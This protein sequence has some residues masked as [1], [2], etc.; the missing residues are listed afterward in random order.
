MDVHAFLDRVFQHLP[1]PPIRHYEFRSWNISEYPTN[2]G[3]GMLPVQGLDPD[4]FIKHVMDVDHYVGN[5]GFVVDN[6]SES[7]DASGAKVRFYQRLKLPVIGAIQHKLE[8]V[9]GGERDG[10]RFAYW[11]MLEDE[12][13]AL[14]PKKGARS[15]Y[16]NGAWLIGHDAVGYALSSGPRR[17]DVGRLTWLALTKGANATAKPTVKQN[18]EGMVR[19]V[20]GK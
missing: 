1:K 3:V 17:E 10:Y 7:M 18:I 16:N 4:N 20:R 12:T 13:A 19:W 14:D 6:H 11:T 2:E 8:L 5:L 15:A 9:D